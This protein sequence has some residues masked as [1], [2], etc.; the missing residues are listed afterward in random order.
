MQYPHVLSHPQEL[1]G[2]PYLLLR[3][4][5]NS[6]AAE[7]CSH[8]QLGHNLGSSNADSSAE[9]VYFRWEWDGQNLLVDNGKLGFFP[10]YYFQSSDLFII[11][12]DISTILSLL[13]SAPKLE[14]ISLAIFLELGFF[15]GDSTPFAGIRAFPPNAQI[16]ETSEGFSV[17]GEYPEV[18]TFTSDRSLAMSR[19][20]ELFRSAIRKRHPRSGTSCA[21]P[22]SGGRDSRHILLELLRQGVTPSECITSLTY[23]TVK[24]QGEVDSARALCRRAGIP[25]T[26]LSQRVSKMRNIRRTLLKTGFCTDEHHWYLV[27]ADYMNGRHSTIYDGI[28]GDVLSAGLFLDSTSLRLYRDGE[29]RKLAENLLGNVSKVPSAKL[30]EFGRDEIADRLIREIALHADNA[31]PVGAF[32]FWNRTRREIAL[33]PYT[34][35]ENVGD[36][37]SPFLDNELFDFLYSLP[38]EMLLDHRFHT[39]VIAKSYPE[40]ADI[41]YCQ[42]DDQRASEDWWTTRRFVMSV[43]VRLFGKDT[44]D[45]V[46]LRYVIPR[47][48]RCIVDN[49]YA[50]EASWLGFQSIYLSDLQ[51]AAS[52]KYT[53]FSGRVN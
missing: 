46:N 21:V 53:S 34:L 30:K 31:N 20:E 23:N 50:G 26:V 33:S 32:Y 22:L 35:I 9:G 11:S 6:W 10:A 49:G 45:A 14:L 43:L 38:G 27:V 16:K 5:D 37:F 24:S 4:A 18:R 3:R 36:V 47:L 2:I 51:R 40:F 8:V 52:R 13:P 48:A 42:S 19:Y 39:D 28:G 17:C 12:A 15:I 41:P 1:N 29:F 7:G 25:H 44:T